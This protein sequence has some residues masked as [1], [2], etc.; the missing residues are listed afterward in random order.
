MLEQLAF[1]NCFSNIDKARYGNQS[2]TLTW[3]P[4]YEQASPYTPQRQANVK[5]HRCT[6][7]G[8]ALLRCPAF[9]A[10]I[11]HRPTCRLVCW[12]CLPC[13][14]LHALLAQI[15][16]SCVH[17]SMFVSDDT[18]QHMVPLS[19]YG[20]HHLFSAASHI[21]LLYTLPALKPI[22]QHRRARLRHVPS[23][24]AVLTPSSAAVSAAS[25]APVSAAP[26]APTKVASPEQLPRCTLVHWFCDCT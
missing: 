16:C 2:L 25:L 8:C 11:F 14:I 18:S 20:I 13:R 15:P 10:T 5:S 22:V 6:R 19:L 17:A 9:V 4:Y 21:G 7:V 24:S 26:S 3:N 23:F 1:T 12:Y